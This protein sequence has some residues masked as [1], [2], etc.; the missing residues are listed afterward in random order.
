MIIDLIIEFL[1]SPHFNPFHYILFW[2]FISQFYSPAYR[3]DQDAS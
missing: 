1:T 3:F 2:L